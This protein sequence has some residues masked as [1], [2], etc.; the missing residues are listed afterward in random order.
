MVRIFCVSLGYE[1]DTNC[2]NVTL[3]VGVVLLLLVLY[4]ETQQQ[5]RFPDARVTDK[6]QF[7]E[8]VAVLSLTYYSAFILI[9]C[10]WR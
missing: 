6:Q 2:A 3:G 10:V 7:E 5:T 1:I 9:F 4:S 8:I